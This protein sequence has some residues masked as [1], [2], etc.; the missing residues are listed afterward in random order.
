[1]SEALCGASG[2]WRKAFFRESFRDGIDGVAPVVGRERLYLVDGHVGGG[3]KADGLDVGVL[4]AGIASHE[5]AHA[6]ADEDDLFGIGTEAGG[7]CGVAEVGD[8]RLYVF[9]GVSKREIAWG[10]PAPAVVEEE[11]VVS[12]AAKGL[13]E[14]KIFLVTGKAMKQ[15]DGGMRGR[16]SRDI[17]EGVEKRA[18]AGELE[19]VECSGVGA[20]G[21][22]VGGDGGGDLGVE[23][24]GDKRADEKSSGEQAHGVIMPLNLGEKLLRWRYD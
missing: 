15:D 16:S 14:I 10:S 22:G 21:D 5:S 6:V 9:D 8:G 1:M 24:S 23:G 3:D 4:R 2:E 12:S 18:V 7:V 17:D 11:H 19:G 20:V 13:S